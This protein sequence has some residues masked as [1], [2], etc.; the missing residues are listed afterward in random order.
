M[1]IVTLRLSDDEEKILEMLVR[2]FDEDKSKIL[3]DALWDKFE[4]LRDREI[5]ED[6]EARSKAGKVEFG[7]A[8]ALLGRIAEKPPAYDA[9]PKRPVRNRPAK[10]PRKR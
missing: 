4:D 3:K 6:Y 1:A 8:D 5:I 2:Y 7:S 10:R 9:G